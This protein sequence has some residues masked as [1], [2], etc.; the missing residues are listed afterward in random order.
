MK[1]SG[2]RQSHQ[3]QM[4]IRFL[5]KLLQTKDNLLYIRNQSVPRCKHFQPRL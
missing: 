2:R 5:G 4:V 1:T 3:C